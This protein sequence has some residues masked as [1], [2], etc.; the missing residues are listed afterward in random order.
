MICGYQANGLRRLY[1]GGA[2]IC[3]YQGE[4]SPFLLLPPQG[5]RRSTIDLKNRNFES[6][7]SQS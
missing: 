6:A 2:M 3:G 5:G 1:A 7:C 4:G